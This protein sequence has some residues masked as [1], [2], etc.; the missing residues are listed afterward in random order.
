ML[1]VHIDIYLEILAFWIRNIKCDMCIHRCGWEVK[2]SVECKVLVLYVCSSCE[3]DVMYNCRF[4]GVVV[5]V[6]L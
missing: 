3:A 1:L 5:K 6:H 2:G 4:P